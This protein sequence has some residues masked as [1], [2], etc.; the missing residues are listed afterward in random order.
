MRGMDGINSAR[1][2]LESLIAKTTSS[3]LH[4][5]EAL[6]GFLLSLAYLSLAWFPNLTRIPE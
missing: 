4:L 1:L 2:V 5:Q 3:P 6:L